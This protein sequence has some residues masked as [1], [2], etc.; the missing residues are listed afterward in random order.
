M[1]NFDFDTTFHHIK[2]HYI[3]ITFIFKFVFYYTELFLSS[4]FKKEHLTHCRM[5]NQPRIGL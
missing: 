2:L 1:G 3:N 5:N 4:C